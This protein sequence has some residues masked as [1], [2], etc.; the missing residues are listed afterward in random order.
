[1]TNG[2]LRYGHNIL[3]RSAENT[4]PLN[5]NPGPLFPL[6]AVQCKKK[7]WRICKL[8]L[9]L[10][11]CGYCVRT[12]GSSW[13]SQACHSHRCLRPAQPSS[14]FTPKLREWP[15]AGL[16]VLLI[17]V[18]TEHSNRPPSPPPHYA[19]GET[20][21]RREWDIS[22][23]CVNYLAEEKPATRNKKQNFEIHNITW[24]WEK[25]I[26]NASWLDKNTT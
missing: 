9:L 12:P 16:L 6:N 25:R 15:S 13:E 20:V 11:K 21:G 3:W 26:I 2:S 22:G 5:K 8:L 18:S 24:N 14:F 17:G 7:R 4:W 19:V 10:R 1:M 23:A